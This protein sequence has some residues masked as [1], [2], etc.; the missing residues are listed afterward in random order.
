MIAGRAKRIRRAA[1]YSQIQACVLAG[2]SPVTWRL[3]EADAESISPE[4]KADC[5]A[6]LL[7]MAKQI[8]E[9]DAA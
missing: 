5:D 3:Y 8:G 9:A 7:K 1:G 2:V 4:K 6:A